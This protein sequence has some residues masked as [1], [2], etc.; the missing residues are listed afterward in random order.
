MIR[1]LIPDYDFL[2]NMPNE[3]FEEFVTTPDGLPHDLM[4][5]VREVVPEVNFIRSEAR[6]NHPEMEGL[7]QEER[8]IAYQMIN[9]PKYTFEDIL[10]FHTQYAL[11]FLEKYPQFKPMIKGVEVVKE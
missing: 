3:L 7:N 2:N 6:V 1:R 11:D 10:D 9:N 8:A 4:S 5:F